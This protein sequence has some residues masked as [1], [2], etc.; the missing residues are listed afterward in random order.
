LFIWHIFSLTRIF[1]VDTY[2]IMS[3]NDKAI[4]IVNVE[5]VRL[6]KQR[7]LREGRSAANAASQTIIE[8]LG[9]QNDTNNAIAEQEKSEAAR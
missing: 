6:A 9:G 4:R 2:I 8:A 1:Y 5:A 7:A 3:V